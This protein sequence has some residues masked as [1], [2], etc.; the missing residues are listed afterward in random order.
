MSVDAVAGD[1]AASATEYEKVIKTE[2]PY[3]LSSVVE[4]TPIEPST[5]PEQERE[6]SDEATTDT[7]P[8]LSEPTDAATTPEATLETVPDTVPEPT[9]D[10]A[11]VPQQGHRKHIAVY[12]SI[13]VL[14]SAAAIAA[15][16]FLLIKRK[17]R[18]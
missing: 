1:D 2:Y 17:L 6:P 3:F 16:Y 9:E 5:P 12:I 15:I 11:D 7:V 13:G 14:I 10:T 18:K 8:D 4:E